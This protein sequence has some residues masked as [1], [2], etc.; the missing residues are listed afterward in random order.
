MADVTHATFIDRRNTTGPGAVP[1]VERRQ[2]RNSHEELSPKA[3][4]LAEAVDQYKLQHRRR[5][6]TY[7]EI[8]QVVESL[9]YRQGG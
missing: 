4:E 8:L 3:R 7:E 6:I 2:F 5:F 1:G 9:G